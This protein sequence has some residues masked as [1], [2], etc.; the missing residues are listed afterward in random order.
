M[1][2]LLF[3][4]LISTTFFSCE[5]SFITGEGDIITQE[6]NLAAFDRILNGGSIDVFIEQGAT[7]SVIVNGQANII[8]RLRTDVNNGQWIGAYQASN[9]KLISMG[10]GD[11]VVSAPMTIS[12]K[13][14]LHTDASGDISISSINCRDLEIRID[15]SGDVQ[16]GGRTQNATY[17]IDGSG[18]IAAFDMTAPLSAV[19]SQGSG[20]VEL[21]VTD[22]FDVNIAASGNV[23]YKGNPTITQSVTGSGRLVDRN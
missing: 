7:Q 19:V 11:F 22:R 4:I 12:N 13:L 3:A 20:N 21:T 14:D 16:V 10:S 23:F 6:L 9:L 17:Y 8:E 5:N 2:K 15:G 18:D 1:K